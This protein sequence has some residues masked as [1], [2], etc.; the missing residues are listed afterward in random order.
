[1]DGVMTKRI[2]LIEHEAE[3]APKWLKPFLKYKLVLRLWR[4]HCLRKVN[5]MT[6]GEVLGRYYEVTGND[7]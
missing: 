7:R 2:Y 4:E 6:V 1:M 3:H 5:K